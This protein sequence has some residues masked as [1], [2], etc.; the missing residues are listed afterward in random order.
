METAYIYILTNKNKTALYTG[1]T[2]SLRKRIYHHKHKLIPGFSKKYNLDQLVYYEICCSKQSALN[3]E[4]QLKK[5]SRKA[6]IKMIEELN[7]QWIDLY[8]ELE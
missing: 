1:S 8:N 5:G 4:T 6:K 3:R 7:P 2:T